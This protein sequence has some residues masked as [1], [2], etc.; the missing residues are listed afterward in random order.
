VQQYLTIWDL[1]L[2]PVYLLVLIAIAKNRRDKKYPVGHP[3]RKYYLPGLYAKFGGAIF[4]GLIYQYYYG[5]GDTFNFFIHAKIIN[6]ALSDS[7]SSWLKLILHT[8]I[9]KAPEIYSY[10]SQLYWYNSPNDY[11]VAVITAVIGLFTFT[12]YLP[13]ALLFAFFAYT[14]IWAMYTTFVHVYPKFIKPLAVA[15]LFIPSTVVWGSGIFKDTVCMF[16]LGWMTYST[17]QIIVNRQFSIRNFLFLVVSIYLVATIKIYIVMAYMPALGLWLMM[18]YSRKIHSVGLRWIV[19]IGFIAVIVGASLYVAKRFANDLN[20][21]SIENLAIKAKRTQEWITYVSD[22]SEGSAYD[23][24]QLDGTLPNMLSKFP[25]AVNVTLYRPYLWES[26]K[27]IILLSAL[28]ASAFLV[29]TLMIFFKMGLIKTFRR[30]FSDA[31]LTFFFIFTLIFA[32][33]VGLSTGNFG[34]LSR[35]KIPCMPFFGAL[36]MILYYQTK[37]ALSN[38]NTTT[39]AKTPVRRLARF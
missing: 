13:T 27:P 19:N 4:I 10:A 30:I 11:A 20:E 39:H 24:G 22:K 33:A 32:F 23:I 37:P 36:L 28:E 25:Q 5:G 21:Y 26:K 12:T 7:F 9:D 34:S 29:L 16:G 17:F 15:F 8:P 6:S 2:T 35:Y 14:G 38:S 31:N 18:N 3:L 1:V